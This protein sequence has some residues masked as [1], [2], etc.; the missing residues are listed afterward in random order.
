M[1][2]V[3]TQNAGDVL[4][5]GKSDVIAD[6]YPHVFKQPFVSPE[7]FARLKAE[8]PADEIFDQNTSVG[9]RA[10]RDLYPGD[11]LY[12]EFLESSN[13]WREFHDYIDSP[14]YVDLVLELFG[15]HLARSGCLADPDRI[16]YRRWIESR[17]RLAEGSTRVSRIVCRVR[18]AL[19]LGQD[20]DAD[21]GEV[22][23][24]MDLAQGA[25]G[26]GKSVHCD[27]PNRL[28]S[29]LIYFSD[30]KEI[31]MEGGNLL[32]HRHKHQKPVERYERHP[33][34][35]LTEVVAEIEPAENLGGMFIGCNNS[36]HSAPVIRRTRGYRNF[37]YTSVASRS[38][39]L[40]R[41]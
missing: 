15:E 25:E 2:T 18:D 34:E 41:C 5:V 30:K 31:G 12:N 33:K 13:A 37:V 3:T 21:P 40:W 38:H 26:Y 23:V 32:V 7:L 22:F 24:R 8:F 10:G 6:P 20:R 17:E 14:S 36:Y 1:T 35:H 11:P 9:G 39:Q 19:G 27:R 4:L 28:T 29:M 16:R